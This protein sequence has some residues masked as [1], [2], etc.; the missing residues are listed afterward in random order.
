MA[1]LAFFDAAETNTDLLEECVYD[2]VDYHVHA[3]FTGSPYEVYDLDTDS[4][5]PP[6]RADIDSSATPRLVKNKKPDYQALRPLFAWLPVAI[7]AKTFNAATQYA[8]MPMSTILKKRYLTFFC[9]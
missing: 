4:S 1:W 7:I 8:P 3:T 6:E 2:C 5:D 9:R